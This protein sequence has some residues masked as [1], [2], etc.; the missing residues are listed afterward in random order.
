MYNYPH[1]KEEDRQKVITFMR[2]HPFIT[3][4]GSSGS[5]RIEVTQLPVLL[6]ERDGKLFIHGHMA[7]KSDHHQAFEERPAA[8]A[9][10]T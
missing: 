9:L 10:F 3:L 6:E 5:S 4:I 2:D 7:R 8:L 1:Y